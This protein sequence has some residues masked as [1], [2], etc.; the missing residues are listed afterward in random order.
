M[1]TAKR[2]SVIGLFL[3][4]AGGLILG[5]GLSLNSSELTRIVLSALGVLVFGAGFL[6]A[7]RVRCDSC[8]NRL[9]SMFPGGSLLLLWAA[10]QKCRS[11]NQWL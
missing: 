1:T 3:V 4:I 8:G 9:S 5:A 11:C 10:K 7:V 6:I 2:T